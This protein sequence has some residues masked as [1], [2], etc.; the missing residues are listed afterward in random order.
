M[1]RSTLLF[2]LQDIYDNLLTALK[3]Q[4]RESDTTEPL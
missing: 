1:I 4:R 2:F 3:L